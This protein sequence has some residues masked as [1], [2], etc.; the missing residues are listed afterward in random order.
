M[1]DYETEFTDDETMDMSLPTEDLSESETEPEISQESNAE[2]EVEQSNL[3]HFSYSIRHRVNRPFAHGEFEGRLKLAVGE[4]I[5]SGTTL[6]DVITQMIVKADEL[7]PGWSV[8][9]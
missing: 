7:M 5:V 8:R 2:L 9:S 1:A 3:D 6:S 4:Y